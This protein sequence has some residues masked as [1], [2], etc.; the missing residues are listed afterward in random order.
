MLHTDTLDFN[1][2]AYILYIYIYIYI[3]IY[4]TTFYM[5]Y[6]VLVCNYTPE[7]LIYRCFQGDTLTEI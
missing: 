5:E 4:L 6:S 1:F 2:I 3:Y 7:T